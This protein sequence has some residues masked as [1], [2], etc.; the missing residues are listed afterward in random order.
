MHKIEFKK[1][2]HRNIE[3]T[4]RKSHYKKPRE[5]FKFNATG[6]KCRMKLENKQVHVIG[7]PKICA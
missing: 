3:R 2:T 6:F 1:K 5:K 7:N 4:N